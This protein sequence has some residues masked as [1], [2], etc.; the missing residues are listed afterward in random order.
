MTKQQTIFKLI[1]KTQDQF[2]SEFNLLINLIRPVSDENTS[3]KIES[4]SKQSI[5][6]NEFIFLIDR[7]RVAPLVWRGLNRE[8]NLKFPNSIKDAISKRVSMNKKRALQQS[9]ELI[10]LSRLFEYNGIQA[11]SLK[12]PIL[13][14]QVYGDIGMRH[15]GDLDFFVDRGNLEKATNLLIKNNYLLTAKYQG[16]NSNDMPVF[17][18]LRNHYEFKSNEGICIELHWRI[19]FNA[20]IDKVMNF[21]QPKISTLTFTNQDINILTP[22]LNFIYLVL[23]GTRHAWF[24][25]KWLCDIAELLEHQPSHLNYINYFNS[26]YTSRSLTQLNL[27]LQTYF[28]MN[29]EFNQFRGNNINKATKC[30]FKYSSSRIHSNIVPSLS[31][32][33]NIIFELRYNILLT[34]IL[35]YKTNFLLT[36]LIV[37]GDQWKI[38]FLLKKYNIMFFIFRPLY[39][40]FRFTINKKNALEKSKAQSN[41]NI[42]N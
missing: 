26:L 7:H 38:E 35:K 22:E 25:L 28:D 1:Q 10:K 33:K 37:V 9:A 8:S 5:N 20:P 4:I 36:K 42:F 13:A 40:A 2:T 21:Q 11:I 6:W 14:K 34:N 23:H 24:R 29:L 18:Q 17:M 30:M 3:N 41:A 27:L 15:A 19:L 39:L 16:I 32:F 31:D 12:G